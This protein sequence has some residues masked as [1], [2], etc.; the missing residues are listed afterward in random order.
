MNPAFD[1]VDVITTA[2]NAM[3]LDRNRKLIPRNVSGNRGQNKALA[4]LLCSVNRPADRRSVI[5]RR[6][7]DRSVSGVTIR[8][9]CAATGTSWPGNPPP[10]AARV[11][12]AEA[13]VVG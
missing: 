13:A 2:L 8:R 10:T 11:S 7:D 12:G 9:S 3:A 5:E 1:A 6:F 4:K